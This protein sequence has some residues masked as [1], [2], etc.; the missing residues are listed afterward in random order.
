MVF[1]LADRVYG[2]EL[3]TVREIIPQRPATRLPGAPPFVAG[4]I[5]VRGTIVTVIDLA[6]RLAGRAA[7]AGGSVIL[8]DH[9][10]KVVGLAV[11]EVLDVQRVADG[12]LSAATEATTALGLVSA[13]GRLD[14]AVVALLEVQDI[15]AP[16]LA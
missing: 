14:H 7:A 6:W 9:G 5:N 1:R 11:D 16:V 15:L 3:A 4:L 2:I 8:V 10:T 13:F 12:S